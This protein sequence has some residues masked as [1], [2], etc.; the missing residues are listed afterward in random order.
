MGTRTLSP[1][2]RMDASDGGRA[3]DTCAGK[4][5]SIFGYTRGFVDTAVQQ[6]SRF[7]FDFFW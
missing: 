3:V 6:T 1:R 7:D 2:V 4:F 5:T